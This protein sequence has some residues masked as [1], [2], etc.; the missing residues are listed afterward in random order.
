MIHSRGAKSILALLLV[1][2]IS[3]PICPHPAAAS[4]KA[5]DRAAQT[6]DTGS[7]AGIED[8]TLLSDCKYDDYLAQHKDAA[9]PE[10]EYA[11]DAA[12][13][14]Q[15][16]GMQVQTADH[17]AGMDGVSVLTGES[18]WIEWTVPIRQSG[19][20]SLSVLYY[21]V[22]GKSSNIQ[23]AVY[24]DGKLPFSEASIVEF[25]RQ[26]GGKS[27]TFQKDNQGDELRPEQI[28]VKAG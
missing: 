18:G 17:Y 4:D 9:R 28:E 27:Q 13:Y 21:P 22:E 25:T 15:S 26:W 12:D 8:F 1:C 5:N 2:T 19:F 23:R 16:S 6:E 7:S 24:I 20:Y 14:T 11:I 10:D 3:F